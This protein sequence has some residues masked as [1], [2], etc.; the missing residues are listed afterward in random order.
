ML[1]V[2]WSTTSDSLPKIVTTH[3]SISFLLDSSSSL[4]VCIYCCCCCCCCIDAL[5]IGAVSYNQLDIANADFA[6]AFELLAHRDDDGAVS[7]TMMSFFLGLWSTRRTDATLRST[8]AH[9]TVQFVTVTPSRDYGVA[10]FACVL[11][12]KAS[13]MYIVIKASYSLSR[14]HYD[15]GG[16]SD[17][18]GHHF[19]W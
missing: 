7:A 5:S 19:S 4:W 15:I 8:G 14:E 1:E 12:L 16:N 9:W 10:G 3:H 13:C 18:L 2:S 6:V 11:L 17:L